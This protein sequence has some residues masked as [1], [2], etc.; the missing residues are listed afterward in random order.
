MPQFRITSFPP[1]VDAAE[2]GSADRWMIRL[3]VDG[4]RRFALAL[5]GL[6]DGCAEATL[7]GGLA[8]AI[9]TDLLRPGWDR[10]ARLRGGPLF[11]G[12]RLYRVFTLRRR[13]RL[14]GGMPWEMECYVEFP[15]EADEAWEGTVRAL[16]DLHRAVTPA[17]TS[18]DA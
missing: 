9:A 3:E 1:T 14:D 4:T 10:V 16:D 8:T 13:C 7:T 12:D 5:R 2:A 17:T 6:D 11:L 18:D 15:I